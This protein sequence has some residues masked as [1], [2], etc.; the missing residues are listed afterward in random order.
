MLVSTATTFGFELSRGA[1]E[2]DLTAK[3]AKAGIAPR[4]GNQLQA[5]ADGLGETGATRLLGPRGD[6]AGLRW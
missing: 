4:G 2:V 3:L 1:V 6:A 5:A